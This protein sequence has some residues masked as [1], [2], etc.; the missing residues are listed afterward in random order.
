MHI[1]LSERGRRQLIKRH[2]QEKR[3]RAADL[4]KAILLSDEGWTCQQISQVLFL[5]EKTIDRHILAYRSKN[6]SDGISEKLDEV[7]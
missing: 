6:E 7:L 2:R 4:I 3:R 5:D 1:F